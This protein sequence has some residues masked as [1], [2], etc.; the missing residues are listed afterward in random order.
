MKSG[1]LK[2]VTV[3][4]LHLCNA[5]A[6]RAAAAVAAIGDAA[7]AAVAAL[8]DGEPQLFEGAGADRVTGTVTI[9]SLNVVILHMASVLA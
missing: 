1:I 3:S 4:E 8:A 7:D 9:S 6:K 2:N 5:A